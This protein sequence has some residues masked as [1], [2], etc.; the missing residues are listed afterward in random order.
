MRTLGASTRFALVL[1]ALFLYV[2]GAHATNISGTITSTM[3]ITQDSQL[4]GD[5]TCTASLVVMPG[6]NPCIQFGFDHIKL[7]LNGHSITGPADPPTGCSVPGDGKPYM[8]GIEAIDRT[9]IQIEGPGVIQHLQRWGILLGFPGHPSSRVTVRN[10]T[11][12][13][14]C[15]SGTQTLSTSDS[16]FEEDVFI[17]NAAGSNGA[18]CGGICL[19]NSNA[20]V[21]HKCK[22]YGNGSLDYSSGNVDFGVGFEGTSSQNRV[23]ESD[24][25]GNTN[26]VLVLDPTAI[27]NIVSHNIIAGNP[28]GQVRK[29]F[30]ASN[31]AGFDIQDNSSAGANTF[32]DNFCLTYEG[33][34]ATAPCPNLRTEGVEEAAG[35]L[36]ILL[37]GQKGSKDPRPSHAISSMASLRA[38][39]DETPNWQRALASS[40]LL[41]LGFLLAVLRISSS[42]SRT[43]SSRPILNKSQLTK[44]EV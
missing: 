31:Q 18:P 38:I 5:V 35:R 25:G 37:N 22:M 41:S 11:L 15:W 28:P 19:S 9:D 39:A 34:A 30:T 10:V 6:A 17:N 14:N 1:F 27:A 8:V 44:E 23:E 4:V 42:H 20:N 21:I 24:I 29:T 43:H 16:N 36:R 3:T 2:G 26:G 32:E 12:N 33:N 40:V 7:K 13:R